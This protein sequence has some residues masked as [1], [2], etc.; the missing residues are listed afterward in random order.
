MKKRILVMGASVIFLTFFCIYLIW[1]KAMLA[2]DEPVVSV[3][4][5]IYDKEFMLE[6][7]TTW[8]NE[9]YYTTDG[10]IPTY[11]SLKYEEPIKIIDRS[12]EENVY[13]NIR[14][15]VDNWLEYDPISDPVEKGTVIR[16]ISVSKWGNSSDIITETYFI[17]QN[18]LAEEESCT[19]SIV[20]DPEELF[21]EEGIYVTGNQYDE[22]YLSGGTQIT[23][24]ILPN[25]YKKIEIAGNIEVFKGK[26]GVLN[27]PSGIRIRGGGSR[28]GELKYFNIFSRDEYSGSNVFDTALYGRTRTHSVMLRPLSIYVA[29]ADILSDRGVSTQKSLRVRVFLN[30]EFWYDAYMLERYDQTYFQEY[31]GIKDTATIIDRMDIECKEYETRAEFERLIE[32]VSNADFTDSAQWDILEEKIDVQSYIDYM[33]ANIYLCNMDFWVD[34]NYRR[35]FSESRGNAPFEDGR[36]RW[37]I[38]DLDVTGPADNNTFLEDMYGNMPVNQNPFYSAFYVNEA[39]RKRFVQ[40]FMDMANNNFSPDNMEPILEKYG[41]D[42]SWNDSFFLK[43]YDYITTYLAEEFKLS[44]TLEKVKISINDADSGMVIINTSTIKFFEGGW[45]GKYYTDYPI[46]IT[47]KANEGYRFVGWEG[48][49][50]QTGEVIEASVEGGLVLRAVFE[51][52]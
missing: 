5:G 52:R 21:G 20:A 45:E 51:K 6:L 26:R 33:A 30:G 25:Y 18:D 47:A 50:E 22:W 31:Y 35:W 40:S 13:R 48:D 46:T 10:S 34:H 42:L 38:Y 15:V 24:E 39:Y 32:W 23:E 3:R 44:G 29:M 49:I 36:M 8:G 17:G 11:Q 19:L 43:R 37:A 2:P 41:M 14:N 27:Q 1:S 4:G 16:A 12:G 7:S 28:G 9:I